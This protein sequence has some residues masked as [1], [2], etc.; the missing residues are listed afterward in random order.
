MSSFLSFFKVKLCAAAD[1]T[2]LEV[3]ILLKNFLKSENFGLTVDNSKH[4]NA[5]GC[6]HLSVGIKL[7]E[8][9]LGV[10]VTLEVNGDVHSVT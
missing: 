7:I 8:N 10:S 5:E 2:A 6:L 3:D 4:N 1:Y 9:N